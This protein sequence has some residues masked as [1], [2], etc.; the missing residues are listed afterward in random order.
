MMSDR[1]VAFP[2]AEELEAAA[3]ICLVMAATTDLGQFLPG[4]GNAQRRRFHRFR[5]RF[6][7][8]CDQ[9]EGRCRC[10]G[11]WLVFSGFYLG[12]RTGGESRG[13]GRMAAP[14]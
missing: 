8:G 12:C 13:Q 11:A 6:K 1:S 2:S 4:S 3:Y 5:K 7:E 10:S 9:D 14:F